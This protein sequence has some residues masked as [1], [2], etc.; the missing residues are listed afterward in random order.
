M[1]DVDRRPTKKS[2]D[3]VYRAHTLCAEVGKH[4]ESTKDTE[5]EKLFSSH[6]KMTRNV[7]RISMEKK[8]RNSGEHGYYP[9]WGYM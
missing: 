2:I 8:E 5:Q 4:G 3:F 9:D 6:Q 7:L 1:G